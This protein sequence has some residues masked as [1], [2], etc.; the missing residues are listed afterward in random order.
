MVSSRVVR[1]FA[2]AAALM[3]STAWS[4][5]RV[6]EIHLPGDEGWDYLAVDAQ[7]QRLHV[8]HGTHVAVVDLATFRSAGA[9]ADTP[10]VHGIALAADLSRGYVSAG[11]ASKV[12]VFDLRN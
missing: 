1:A 2:L 3:S 5:H 8:S 4:Y 7:G 6:R 11:A 10:G 9:I 12:V